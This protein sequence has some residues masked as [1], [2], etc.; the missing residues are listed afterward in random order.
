MKIKYYLWCITTMMLF[1]QAGCASKPPSSN[2]EAPVGTNTNNSPKLNVDYD[3]RQFLSKGDVIAFNHIF[4]DFDEKPPEK[5][6]EWKDVDPLGLYTPAQNRQTRRDIFLFEVTPK[7]LQDNAGTPNSD[8]IAFEQVLKKES[9]SVK[10]LLTAQTA[11]I[12]S[13][14][15][16]KYETNGPIFREKLLMKTA[17]WGL[18]WSQVGGKSLYIYNGNILI[19]RFKYGYVSLPSSDIDRPFNEQVFI[20]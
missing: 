7:N 6:W 8:Q 15:T 20:K 19:S 14:F 10:V 2:N 5:N 16:E 4:P 11:K 12:L 13:P 9:P 1:M 3:A 18:R 17:S